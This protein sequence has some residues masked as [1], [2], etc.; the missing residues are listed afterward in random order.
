MVGYEILNHFTGAQRRYST[1]LE[2]TN[3]VLVL[4]DLQV[5][6]APV[7]YEQKALIENTVKLIRGINILNIPILWVEHNP[8]GLG[9]TVP[10]VAELI[11]GKPI[12]KLSFSCCDERC[13]MEALEN[14]KRRQILLAGIESH[15]CIYQTAIDLLRSAYEVEVVVDATSSRTLQNKEI[16]LQKVKDAGGAWTSVETVLFELLKVAEGAKFREILKIVK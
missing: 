7:M 10:E 16:G 1:M 13:F 15:I 4:V 14:S 9:K 11:S 6:L 8:R 3:T 2:N 12:T 5:K